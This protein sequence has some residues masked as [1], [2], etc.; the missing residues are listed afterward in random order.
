[1]TLPHEVVHI[2][3]LQEHGGKFGPSPEIKA[4]RAEHPE[5]LK[6]EYGFELKTAKE[7][8]EYVKQDE[9]YH[10]EHYKKHPANIDEKKLSRIR[11]ST[12]GEYKGVT[13]YFVD[14]AYIRDNTDVDFVVG[15]NPGRYT[16]VPEGDI[17]IEQES[18][19]K[20][21]VPFMLHEYSELQDMKSGK[22]YDDAHAKASEEE[23]ACRKS[24]SPSGSIMK[25]FVDCL[26]RF[27][28]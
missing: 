19:Q 28:K 5:V 15:G 20:D 27:S 7:K 21:V 6:K 9:K 1:V 13:F 3:Q 18:D 22:S 12:I 23:I 14:G 11:K 24:Y 2:D 26:K 8:S 4:E 16:Y 25:D 10:M 17:W